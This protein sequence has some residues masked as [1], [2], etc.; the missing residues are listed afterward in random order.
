MLKNNAPLISVLMGTLYI[1][2]N[3]D[4]LKRSLESILSQ[5]LSS[6]EFIICDDGSSNE[7]KELLNKYAKQDNRIRV[8]R[9]GNLIKL[10]PKLNSCLKEARGIY[11][12]R[13][14]DDDYSHPKRFEKQAAI[15]ES[16]RKISF[17]G[18]NVNLIQVGK[19][20]G[21]RSF[22][23]YPKVRDFYI[24]Q[25]YIHPALMF[26]KSVLLNV[27]GYSENKYQVLC[28]DYDLLLRL[29]AAGYIGTNL[30]EALLD[31]S[32]PEKAKGNRRMIHRWNEVITRWSRFRQL[33]LLPGA[34]PYVIKPLV[35]GLLP[36]VF[37]SGIKKVRNEI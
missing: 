18:C 1:R 36:E 16:E 8:I 15:L 37:L 23:T 10:A 28:E 29:Y 7:A 20:V 25:P 21:F 33:G 35:V 17:V 32:I 11:I 9:V 3:L 30:Q 27:S 24:T 6:F 26:R 31:Y 2:K 5:T 19:T 34:L 14:D 12:A 22:P 4:I 13:M